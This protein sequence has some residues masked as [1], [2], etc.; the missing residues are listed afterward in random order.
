MIENSQDLLYE[1][2]NKQVKGAKLRGNIRWELEGKKWLKTFFKVFERQ[3]MQIQTISAFYTDY[4]KSKYSSN[5]K[6]I[7]KF[8]KEIYEKLYNKE[9]TSKAPILNFLAKFLTE[10]K[11]LINNLIFVRRKYL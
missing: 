2:E 6:D 5:P 8:S 4:N 10:R 1:L 9:T 11:Y 3:N 7:F